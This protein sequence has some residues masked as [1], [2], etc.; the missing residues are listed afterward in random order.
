MIVFD[1]VKKIMGGKTVLDLAELQIPK[2]ALYGLIGAN[3]AGK[4]TMMRLISGVYTAD[5]GLVTVDGENIT[6]NAAVKENMFFV[7]DDPYFLPQ[8]TLDDMAEFYRCY[9]KN[10]DMVLYEQLSAGFELPVKNK[11]NSFSKGMRRQAIILLALAS[12]PKYLLLDESFD[13][14]DPVMRQ[15]LRRILIDIALEKKMT[16]V[17]SSHNLRELDEF[18]DRV[19]VVY[20]GKLLYDITL[21]KLREEVHRYQLAFSAPVEQEMFSRFRLLSCETI[22]KFATLVIRGER[23]VLDRKI[24]ELKPLAVEEFPLSLEEIFI[25]EMEA[26]GYE[27]KDIFA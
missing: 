1:R 13:G 26:K 12:G 19:G 6:D 7:P 3:G 8:A 11:I 4:S 2:G 24:R 20:Q 10:F 18:C 15:R 25:Y 5:S 9:Y 16:V 17:I 14:L 21:E 22:G 23:A 27:Y